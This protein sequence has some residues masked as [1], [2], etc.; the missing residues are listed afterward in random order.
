MIGSSTKI[1]ESWQVK[2]CGIWSLSCIA[3]RTWTHSGR[4]LSRVFERGGRG[5]LQ[6]L[7]R[8]FPP[9]SEREARM[10]DPTRRSKKDRQTECVFRGS[11]SQARAPFFFSGIRSRDFFALT[12]SSGPKKSDLTAPSKSARPM[13]PAPRAATREYLPA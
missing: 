11:R 4:R 8:S 2:M 13:L 7:C 6:D 9:A 12:K 1:R 10:D 5:L 3:I